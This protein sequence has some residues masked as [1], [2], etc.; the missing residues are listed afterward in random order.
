MSRIRKQ[1]D[2]HYIFKQKERI[3]KLVK[4]GKE[5]ADDFEDNSEEQRNMYIALSAINQVGDSLW[6]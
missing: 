2:I 1:E 4:K 6:I 5:I 3:E